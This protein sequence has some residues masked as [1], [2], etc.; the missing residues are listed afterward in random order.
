MLTPKIDMLKHEASQKE[1]LVIMEHFR[2][3]LLQHFKI[4]DINSKRL[5][6]ERWEEGGGSK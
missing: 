3:A 4:V 2:N 1:S 6:D 5:I